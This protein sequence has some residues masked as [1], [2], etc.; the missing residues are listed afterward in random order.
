MKKNLLFIVAILMSMQLFCQIEPDLDFVKIVS[1]QD[2]LK[3]YP[4]HKSGGLKL[5]DNYDLKYHRLHLYIDPAVLYVSGSVHSH[6]VATQPMTVIQFELIDTLS[7]DS[8]IYH[9]LHIPYMHINKTLTIAFPSTIPSGQLD[10]VSVYYQGV[11]DQGAGFGSFIQSNHA[12]T[13][14]IST[15]S[16]P[17]GA[18]DW[19]PCKNSLS[20][21]ID[22]VDIIVGTPM[23][24]R[25]GSNGLL[26]SEYVSGTDK[27]YHW[28][29]K[30]PI[31]TY[32]VAVAVTNYAVYSDYAPLGS[33]TLE[34]L[35]YVFPEDLAT[36]QASTPDLIPVMQLYSNL[37][38]MY[39]YITEKYGHAQFNWGGGMEHQTMTFLVNFGYELMAH[40]LSHQWFGDKITCD[41][42]QNIWINEGFATYLTALTYDF[43]VGEYWWNK[44]KKE[45]VEYITSEP[46]G[47]V[48][49]YDTSA[50][51]RIFDG[52]L[53][54]NKGAM[55]LNML[56]WKTG[57]S[58]F[59]ASLY[60]YM[61]DPA[62]IY[63]FAGTEDFQAHAEAASGMNLDDFFHDWIYMEG[64]PVYS[65]NCTVYPD[66]T[67]SLN[68]QQATS[69]SSVSFF[70]LPVPVKFKNTVRDTLLVFDHTFS[71]E[72]FNFDLDFIPD[73]MI[74][75]PTHELIAQLGASN[76][77]YGI[78]ETDLNTVYL[79]PNPA[80]SF[81]TIINLPECF[82]SGSITDVSGRLVKAFEINHS[83]FEKVDVM[84]DF[85]GK[86]I[87]FI[88]LQ[89]ANNNIVR[90]FVK[91]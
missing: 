83:G 22:S 69:H 28:K 7:V 27:I 70:S 59:F 82:T 81:I 4:K 61:N 36:A 57:D 13:P 17:Y 78:G 79:Y 80:A 74:F 34:I 18:S 48:F 75:D 1:K 87:Y 44:W 89:S 40:E 73:S 8:V 25:V 21:K 90:K 54:Y 71:G 35:N 30:Y 76:L 88:K 51:W 45:T 29:H 46:D 50:V 20:D 49:C 77:I 66:S 12:G 64:F 63:G 5:G 53:S 47:S 60:N 31:V 84:M 37:F 11:P 39:P 65:L 10:S 68:I 2:A 6:F 86:G 9:G 56:R 72:T 14:V 33:D 52:R 26:K 67:A 23:Q 85:S 62:L 42:W 19:W 41:S 91:N 16:E 58:S 3:H 38:G 32:L 15:L 43:I 24:Y 55:V